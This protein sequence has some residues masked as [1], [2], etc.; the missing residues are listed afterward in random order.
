MV[1]LLSVRLPG[2]LAHGKS[3]YE[4]LNDVL[5]PELKSV[6]YSGSV[7]RASD[8]IAHISSLVEVSAQRADSVVLV[9][10]SLG[11]MLVPFVVSTLSEDIRQQLKIVIVDAPT[12]AETIMDSNARFLGSRVVGGTFVTVMRA[13]PF[14]MPVG[15]D[16]LPKPSEIS[17][18]LDV[19]AVRAQARDDLNGHRLSMFF[20][21]TAWMVRVGRDGLHNED[22]LLKQVC[23]SLKGL[24]VTYLSCTHPGN[25]VVRQPEA[26]NWWNAYSFGVK[27]EVVNG[28]HCGYLQN[29]PEF[30]RA[31][32]KIL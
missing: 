5:P 13:L 3:Q 21:Q 26:S 18:L 22:G 23:R 10:S 11:G 31:F 8:E 20:S 24:D 32:E 9:G 2:V 16:M 12:G 27:Q 4:P 17:N 15:D 28:T 29:Q 30:V 7:F 1:S 6:S 19:D 14:N 25:G